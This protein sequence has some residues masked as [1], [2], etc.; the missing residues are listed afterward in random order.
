MQQQPPQQAHQPTETTP[1]KR[2][3]IKITDPNSGKDLTS[4]ILKKEKTPVRPINPV[5]ISV[6]ETTTPVK[7]V[8]TDMKSTDAAAKANAAFAAKVLALQKVSFQPSY[9]KIKLAKLVYYSTYSMDMIT[10]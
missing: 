7:P 6:P 5:K 2:T 10:I 8:E 9:L 4:E 1:K 3:T